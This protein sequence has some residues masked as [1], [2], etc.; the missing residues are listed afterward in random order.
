MHV[1]LP[2]GAAVLMG[3][4]SCSAFGPPPVTGNNF[5]ISIDTESRQDTAVRGRR[6]RHGPTGYVLGLL[7]RYVYRSLW[8]QLDAQLR[9]RRGMTTARL[10]AAKVQGRV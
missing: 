8:R 1:S 4:D 2:I 3:S 6:R 5:S 7:L 9:R 10:R